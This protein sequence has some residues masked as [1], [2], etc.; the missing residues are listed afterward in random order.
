MINVYNRRDKVLACFFDIALR[1]FAFIV[2]LIRRQRYQMIG[3]QG[4]NRILVIRLDNIGDV[5][6]TTPLIRE[7]KKIFKNAKID[8]LVNPYAA[9]VIKSNPN[10]SNIYPYYAFWFNR[11]HTLWDFFKEFVQII[12]ILKRKRYD[13]VIEPRGDIRNML[14]AFILGIKRRLGF[15]RTGGAY[16]LTDA[17]DYKPGKH[18]IRHQQDLLTYL[19]NKKI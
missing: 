15:N 12:R 16:M 6:M 4:V 3:R 11:S 19:D 17:L 10:I 14:F 1:P 18:F 2:K 7:L 5:V 8:I 9:Q 13:L